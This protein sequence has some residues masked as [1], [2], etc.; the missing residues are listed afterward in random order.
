MVNMKKIEKIDIKNLQP[1]TLWVLFM[2]RLNELTEALN[3]HLE[4]HTK[5]RED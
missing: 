2:D 1:I 3:K 4:N 5:A